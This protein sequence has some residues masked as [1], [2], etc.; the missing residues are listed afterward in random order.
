MV[1]E[2]VSR[3]DCVFKGYIGDDFLKLHISAFGSWLDRRPS[4]VVGCYFQSTCDVIKQRC[5][6]PERWCPEDISRSVLYRGRT[7]LTDF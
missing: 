4:R 6:K 2:G 5:H 1:C 3:I 7:P